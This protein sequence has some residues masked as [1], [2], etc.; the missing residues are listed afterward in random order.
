[1]KRNPIAKAL[2][3]SHLRKQVVPNKKKLPRHQ[4]KRQT[5]RDFWRSLLR[6]QVNLLFH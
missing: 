2:R 5:F 4:L 1:M 6:P 3:S